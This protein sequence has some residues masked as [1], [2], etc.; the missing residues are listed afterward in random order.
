METKPPFYLTTTLPY[1]NAVPHIG[2]AMEIVRADAI[3][4]FKKLM[5]Y[6]V[7]FNTGT[8]E[9][10]QKLYDGA[11]K[12]GKHIQAYV[13]E[14]AL[15]FK[16]L[17]KLLSVSDDVHFIRTTDENHIKGAQALWTRVM[18]NGYIYK[19][20]YTTKYC[21]GCELEK[22]DSELIDGRCEYHPNAELDLIDEE[23]YFFAFSKFQQKLLDL[24][25]TRA[26][27]VVPDFRQNEIRSFVAAGL[28]DFSVSRLSA[29]MSW[30]IAVPG[31]SEHV[32][33]VWFDALA[34][35]ITTLG[36]PENVELFQRFWVNGTPVQYAGQDN[37]RQQSAMWQAI[38][39]AADLPTSYQIHINGFITGSDGRKMSKSLGNGVDPLPLV[40]YY[41]S[42]AV[43]YYLL[44][45]IHPYDGSPVGYES[46]HQ[47]YTSD[48]VNG[49]G[50]LTSRLMNLC[51]KHLESCPVVPEQSLPSEWLGHFE[52]FRSDLAC[53][54]V[55]KYVADLDLAITSTEPFKLIKT[56]PEAAKEL[57]REYVT[58]LYT[59]ARMLHPI[60]PETS[61]QIK[62]LIKENK[63]PSNPLFPRLEMFVPER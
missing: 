39:M 51:E 29:K 18:D 50:N 6:D 14:Y 27:F 1:V 20:S 46:I 38:L 56:Q 60:M 30:G 17:P 44:H 54:I 8:D 7:F 26:D 33:Y 10:G 49:I 3:V 13:D 21:I 57:L 52:N 19:K 61:N 12:E 16:I 62:S 43:R 24:Y 23:N 34:N 37:L 28:Q 9:H 2:F 53:S 45:Y 40:Q 4:R 59:V 25:S 41:G 36:W 48:L 35:Y 11:I 55:M 22:T 32:M 58:K 5:G 63:K 47:R 31:D 15:K 42:D